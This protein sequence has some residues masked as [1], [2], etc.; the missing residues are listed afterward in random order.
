MRNRVRVLSSV[1][2]C[3]VLLTLLNTSCSKRAITRIQGKKVA[4]CKGFINLTDEGKTRFSFEVFQLNDGTFKSFFGTGLIKRFRAVDTIS[5]NDG[6]LRIEVSSPHHV[7]EGTLS[8][9]NLSVEG[10]WNEFKGIFS[11]DIDN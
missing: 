1:I 10:E 6:T 2:L 11:L 8:L 9:E 7:Y 3:F 4:V 5:F